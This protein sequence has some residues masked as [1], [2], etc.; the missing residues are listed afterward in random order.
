MATLLMIQLQSFHRLIFVFPVAPFAIIGVVM[1]LLL[2]GT[3]MG[4]EAI[5]GILA[6]IDIL[7]RNSVILIVQIEY[8]CDS[9]IEGWNAIVEATDHRMRPILLTGAAVSLALIPISRDVGGLW[10]TP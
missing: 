8:L 9:G 5:L 6:L 3:P 2:T 4:F 10:H 1:A 7:I